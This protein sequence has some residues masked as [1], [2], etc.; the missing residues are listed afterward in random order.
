MTPAGGPSDRRVDRRLFL[1]GIAGVLT[2]GAAGCLGDGGGDGDGDDGGDGDDAGTSDDGGNGDDA[3]PEATTPT[4]AGDGDTSDPDGTIAGD[5]DTATT[6]TRD[7]GA[8]T[9]ATDPGTTTATTDDE[10]DLREA[11]VTGVEFERRNGSHRF[12]VTLYHDDA[13]EEGYANWWQV[14]RLDGER[15]G[16]RDLLHAHGT[17][18][19]TRSE[20]ITV[21]D[22]TTRVVVRGHDQAHGYG[23]QAAVV[24]L[25][26]GA[27]EFVRQGS[28]PDSFADRAG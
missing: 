7:P 16:R 26:S 9:T 27:V 6:G 18:E 2:G 15:L 1:G 4:T 17:R 21:P 5:D 22:G 14:E 10:L 28:D 3:S 23:G 19:F 11:N 24:D 12:S 20:T 8:E 13:G 25:E